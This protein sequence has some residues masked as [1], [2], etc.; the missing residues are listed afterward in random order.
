M[1]SIKNIITIIM[2]IKEMIKKINF[3]FIIND[4]IIAYLFF[5]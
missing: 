2:L 4:K 1:I 3:Y 5:Y